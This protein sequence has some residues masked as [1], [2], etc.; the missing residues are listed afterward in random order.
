MAYFKSIFASSS[1]SG[2][3]ETL[4]GIDTM[5]T[6]EMN[7]LLDLEPTREEIRLALFQLHPTKAPGTYGFHALFFQKFW[8]IIGDDVI[9]LVKMWWRGDFDLKPINKTCIS[10]VPKCHDPKRMIEFHPISCCNVIY[11]IISKFMANKLKVF[12]GDIISVN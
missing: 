2:F 3:P 8:D 6:E 5:V 1:P 9:C 11:K 7:Q 10:L 12:L 4:E